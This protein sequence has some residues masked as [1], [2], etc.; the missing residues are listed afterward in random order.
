MAVEFGPREHFTL[1][2]VISG[3]G[4]KK[5]DRKHKTGTEIWILAYHYHIIAESSSFHVHFNKDKETEPAS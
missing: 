5:W 3:A 4:S 2:C 1:E